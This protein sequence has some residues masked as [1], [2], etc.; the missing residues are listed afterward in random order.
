MTDS[1]ETIEDQ[2]IYRIVRSD[3]TQSEALRS[4]RFDENSIT[5]DPL[6]IYAFNQSKRRWT[7]T[8]HTDRLPK[9]EEGPCPF[10]VKR[11]DFFTYSLPR[12]DI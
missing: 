6:S 8:L 2:R 9:R 5:G 4:A 11:S 7:R 1:V 3:S 10:L 12:S